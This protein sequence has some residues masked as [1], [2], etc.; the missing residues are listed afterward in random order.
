[1]RKTFIIIGVIVLTTIITVL[2]II[3]IPKPVKVE[4]TKEPVVT[5]TAEPEQLYPFDIEE[6]F[7]TNMKDSMRYVRTSISLVLN[8]EEDISV[9]EKNIFIIKDRVIG[10]L[11]GV[12]EEEYL[13]NKSQEKLKLQIKSELSACLSIES[14]VDVYFTELV[15]Q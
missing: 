1:M 13:E 6:A 15:V 11:R 9:L 14:L 5:E 8:N 12:T 7:V 3:L 4:A 2:S 10:I